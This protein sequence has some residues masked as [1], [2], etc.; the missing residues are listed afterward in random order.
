M[1]QK[2]IKDTLFC[3]AVDRG[4]KNG[5]SEGGW[6][7]RGRRDEGEKAVGISSS[8]VMVDVGEGKKG[9]TRSSQRHVLRPSR[10]A[11]RGDLSSAP[12]TST[13]HILNPE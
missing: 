4:Q 9:R 6:R 12:D 7:R 3:F 8:R 1:V 13:R 5:R 10:A 2:T 11:E